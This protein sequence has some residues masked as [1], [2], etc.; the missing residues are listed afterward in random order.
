[1]ATPNIRKTRERRCKNSLACN[2]IETT[3]MGTLRSA[4]RLMNTAA[5]SPVYQRPH[6]GQPFQRLSDA[7]PNLLCFD[8]N[9]LPG[10]NQTKSRFLPVSCSH[11]T[12]VS[13]ALS[14]FSLYFQPFVPNLQP[15]RVCP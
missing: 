3:D 15:N 14:E 6:A 10:S 2:S 12:L 9:P 8:L 1:M 13:E 7:C 4:P 5:F 11:K